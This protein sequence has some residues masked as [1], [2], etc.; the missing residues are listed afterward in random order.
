[1]ESRKERFATYRE[2]IRRMPDASF[3]TK[4]SGD[5]EDVAVAKD[6]VKPESVAE[7]PV[8]PYGLYLQKR[9]RKTLIKVVVL[10]AVIVVFV[11]W[12]FLL[13]GRK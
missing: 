12:W 1:M 10:L 4:R 8:G 3:P 5:A 6:T 2:Q 13:Q 9:R 11:V 7:T